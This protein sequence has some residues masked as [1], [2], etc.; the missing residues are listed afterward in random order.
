MQPSFLA[1]VIQAVLAIILIMN[2]SAVAAQT[3]KH[4]SLKVDNKEIGSIT[5]LSETLP[6][7]G[8]KISQNLRIKT[9]GFWSSLDIAGALEETISAEGTLQEAS[10]KIREN[11]KVY[12]SKLSRSGDEYL[13][14]R[15][16]MKSDEEKDIDELA[17]LAKGVVTVLVP[18]AGDVIE[19]GTLLLSDDRNNPKHD[20]LT[21]GSFDT[22]LAGLPFF[23]ERNAYQLPGKLR[24]FDTED[25]MILATRIED[26]GTDNLT[27]G[28][29][30]VSTRHYRLI[31]KGS[32]PIDIWLLRAKDNSA[33]F[34]QVT[35]KESGS[36]FQLTLQPGQ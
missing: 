15:A 12:W 32:D 34:A 36:A 10:S 35:G 5:L 30:R 3:R 20:R 33:Y 28:T 2:C 26:L 27:I 1:K 29:V 17:S 21:A 14:F 6:K 18:G 22:S 8:R 25:M 13:S 4:Y 24:V 19:I 11:K 7:G 23:W 16:Q 31:I 9:S